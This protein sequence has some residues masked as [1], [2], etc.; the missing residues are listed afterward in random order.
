MQIH[1]G[2]ALKICSPVVPLS[3]TIDSQLYCLPWGYFHVMGET[4]MCF[5]LSAHVVGTLH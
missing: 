2:L 1:M 5:S 4:D 3:A